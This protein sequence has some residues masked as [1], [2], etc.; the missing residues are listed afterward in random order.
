MEAR[1]V[2]AFSKVIIRGNDFKYFV[3]DDGVLII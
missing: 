2:K 1:K 3:V